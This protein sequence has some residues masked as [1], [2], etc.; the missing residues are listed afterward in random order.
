MPFKYN[1]FTNKFDEVN[2]GGGGSSAD[3]STTLISTATASSDTTIDF[4]GLS[5]NMYL[6]VGRD[7]MYGDSFSS[8]RY[9]QFRTRVQGGSFESGASD[10]AWSATGRTSSGS[11][12]ST[13]DSADS[14]IVSRMSSADTDSTGLRMY[15]EVYIQNLATASR[16][17]SISGTCYGTDG[18]HVIF[19]GIRNADQDDDGIQI[20][21]STGKIEAGTFYLYEITEGTL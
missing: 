21:S 4:T 15:C 12:T 5:A 17:T 11:S 10:Y 6:L 9:L 19:S 20:F 3:R 1:P 16:S 2:S 14:Q 7:V 8:N 13:N 18:D